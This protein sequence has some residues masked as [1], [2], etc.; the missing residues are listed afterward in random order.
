MLTNI[1]SPRITKTIN[2]TTW[3]VTLKASSDNLNLKFLKTVTSKTFLNQHKNIEVNMY[4]FSLK[5]CNAA[6]CVTNLQA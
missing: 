2:A 1:F 6:S 4:S 5:N 3:Y